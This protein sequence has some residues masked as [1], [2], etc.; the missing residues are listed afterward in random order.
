MTTTDDDQNRRI[1]GNAV[2]IDGLG[3][4][5]G[6]LETGAAL[7]GQSVDNLG[8]AFSTGMTDL[9]DVLKARDEEARETRIADREQQ[10]WFWGKVFGIVATLL[11]LAGGGGAVWWST[12]SP[13]APGETPAAVQP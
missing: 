4:R 3:R 10:R 13:E 8:V 2:K 9:K 7:L 6:E 1:E 5:V 12:G 11:T